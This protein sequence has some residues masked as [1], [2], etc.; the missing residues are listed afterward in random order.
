MQQFSIIHDIWVWFASRKPTKLIIVSNLVPQIHTSS[1]L[2]VRDGD[3]MFL[4]YVC[5]YLHDMVFQP[6]TASTVGPQIL[7]PNC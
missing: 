5:I 2:M 7:H 3:S 1:F 6:R 4:Q